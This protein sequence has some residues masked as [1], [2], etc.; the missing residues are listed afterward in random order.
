M[1]NLPNI[2]VNGVAKSGTT[3]MYHY[4]SE[5]PDIY[6]PARKEMNFFSYYQNDTAVFRSRAVRIE[7]F[8]EYQAYYDGSQNY[9]FRGDVSPSYFKTFGTAEKI[10]KHIPAAKF[11]TT[12]R[13]PID[14]AFSGYQMQLRFNGIDPKMKTPFSPDNHWVELGLYYHRLKEYFDNFDRSQ[15]HIVLLEDMNSARVETLNGVFNYIGVDAGKYNFE[16]KEIHNSGFV[17]KNYLMNNLARNN[18]FINK[19][20]TPLTPKSLKSIARKLENLNKAKIEPMSD[21]D[22]EKLGKFYH[23]DVRQLEGL[24]DRDLSH[25]C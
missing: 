13:N 1:N 19:Y 20:I 8:D 6:M 7:S 16:Q 14:R 12:L 18:K 15:I 3:S 10:K 24:I 23:D 22:R 4:L 17:P 25:W 5:H 2:I 9:L 11:I 21:S